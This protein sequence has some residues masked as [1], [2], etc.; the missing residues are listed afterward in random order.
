MN[1]VSK[2][3]H[4]DISD[5]YGEY[6]DDEKKRFHENGCSDERNSDG[7]RVINIADSW[8]FIYTKAISIN[9]NDAELYFKRAKY[10]EIRDRQN[11]AIADYSEAI[12][13]EPDYTDAY[14][15]RSQCYR[16]AGLRDEAISDFNEVIRLDPEGACPVLYG[17]KTKVVAVDII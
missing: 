14:L 16:K 15:K 11:E 10:Y 9:P 2:R 4:I 7:I 6:L 17:F 8:I 1:F 5:L 13:L 3:T 12:R